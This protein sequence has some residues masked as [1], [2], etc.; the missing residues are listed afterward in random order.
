MVEFPHRVRGQPL[1]EETS[2]RMREILVEV[3]ERGTG[4]YLKIPGLNY[5]GKTGTTEIAGNGTYSTQEYISSFMAFA[6]AEDPRVV[7]L[8]MIERPK[9]RHYGSSVAGP[10]VKGILE[11]IYPPS[12][13]SDQ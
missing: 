7:V 8:A 1:R 11:R 13:V 5:G 10:V 2:R 9:F 4:K 3:V 12:V 6:P